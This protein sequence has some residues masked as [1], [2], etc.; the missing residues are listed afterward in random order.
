MD[1]LIT[2]I[3]CV[4]GATVSIY[5]PPE[6]KYTWGFIVASV[7]RLIAALERL[8]DIKKGD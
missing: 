1:I 2:I 6:L 5:L 7:L 8:N 3:V 4:I